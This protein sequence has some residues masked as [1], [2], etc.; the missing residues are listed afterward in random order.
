ME[1]LFLF[2]GASA[3]VGI[4]FLGTFFVL[5]RVG[6]QGAQSYAHPARYSRADCDNPAF[7]GIYFRDIA[8]STEDGIDL[9]AWYTPSQN[10]AVILVAHGFAG[11]RSA[12]MH[13]LF[14]KHGYGVISWDARAHGESGGDLSTWGYYE[15]RDVAAA[16]DYALNVAS[17]EKV[18]AFGESMGAATILLAA[19][20][21]PQIQA[22]V[23]DSAFAAIGDLIHIVSP[24]PIFVPFI[25]FFAEWETGLTVDDLR[26]VDAIGTISPRPVFLIQGEADETVPPESALMLYDVAGE[27]RQLW[28]APG[29]SHVGMSAAY[30]EEYETR[31]IGFFDQSSARH[32]PAITRAGPGRIGGERQAVVPN[33]VH[34]SYLRER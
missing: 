32:A 4:A 18:G 8:L 7:H 28:V 19:A 9:A 27:P 3:V 24:Y 21:Q 31:V 14:A 10:G 22:V 25:Q 26:P 15:R 2:L 23:A 17:V 12:R 11:R 16:L 13:A 20:E 33:D 6:Y 34:G 5:L 1:D 30:P 29:V